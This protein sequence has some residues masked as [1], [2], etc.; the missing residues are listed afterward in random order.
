MNADAAVYPDNQQQCAL[1]DGAVWPQASKLVEISIVHAEEFACHSRIDDV[2]EEQKW[3]RETQDELNKLPRREAKCRAVGQLVECEYDMG[4]ESRSENDR[5]GP[6]PRNEPAPLLDLVH[7]LQIKKAEGMI[8]EVGRRKREKDQPRNEAGPLPPVSSEKDVHVVS[9]PGPRPAVL[10][11][12]L[13]VKLFVRRIRRVRKRS[14]AVCSEC[15]R[16][17]LVCH[18]V[19]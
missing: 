17:C 14:A 11:L 16:A 6:G 5:T 18:I 7:R 15:A 1:Q 10:F 2:G 9:G 3:D 13:W 12:P 4:H 19:A 8:E